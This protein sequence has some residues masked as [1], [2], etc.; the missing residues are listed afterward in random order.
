MMTAIKTNDAALL[1]EYPDALSEDSF[2]DAFLA[3]D[4]DEGE[5]A[6]KPSDK[7]DPADDQETPDADADAD[8]NSEETPE[9]DDGDD[10]GEGTE[11]NDEGNDDEKSE[12]KFADSD[13]VYTK[14]TVD[15]QEHEVSIKELKRL[16]GQEASLTRKSQEVATERKAIDEKRA[17]NIAAYDVLLKRATERADK[18]RALPW[19]Q[20]MKDPEVPADQLQALQA[21]AREALQDEQFLTQELGNF[22]TQ[23]DAE[24]KAAMKQQA[25][26]CIKALTTAD[27]P[28]H[29]K[30]WNDALY[31]D[32]RK[33]GTEMGIPAEQMN[34]LVDPASFKVL[35]MAMQFKRGASKVVT[36]KVNKTPTKI[37]KNSASAPA[38]RGSSK[39]TS[40]K[41]AVNK[42]AK[43]GSME[44][45]AAAFEA[46]M[47][48]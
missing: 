33:F 24:Q 2:A 28:H 32:I 8:E 44:D 3:G 47:G 30:G 43:T 17:S 20:L 46:L 48:D 7:N 10:E 36:K 40:A 37:V 13:D 35:H 27:S 1:N 39:Q 15:G 16:Y 21:E 42:A 5:D 6:E 23:I 22:M 19:T 26:E 29:I 34:A 12:R 9:G 4:P 31:S 18:Y 45:A 25:G 41:A 11:E 38:A 14:V